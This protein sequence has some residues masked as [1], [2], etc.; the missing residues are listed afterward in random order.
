M[1]HFLFHSND[2]C[3]FV[4]TNYDIINSR[5]ENESQYTTVHPSVFVIHTKRHENE[6]KRIFR[7]IWANSGQKVNDLSTKTSFECPSKSTNSFTRH[8]FRVCDAPNPQGQ[9]INVTFLPLRCYLWCWARE[10][11][12]TPSNHHFYTQLPH[13]FRQTL[14]KLCSATKTRTKITSSSNTYT[15]CPQI[16]WWFIATPL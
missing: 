4:F 10:S 3:Y 7:N 8:N 6:I 2:F 15:S 13:S 1:Q 11:I 14:S 9:W 16:S 5:L 12:H